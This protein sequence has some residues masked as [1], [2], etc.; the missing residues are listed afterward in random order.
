MGQVVYK[1]GLISRRLRKL[2]RSPVGMK[3]KES[4]TRRL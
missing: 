2:I 1:N 4:I 3:P